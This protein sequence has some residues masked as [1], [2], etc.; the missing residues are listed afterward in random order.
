[1]ALAPAGF[2]SLGGDLLV[3]NFGDGVINAYDP[4]TFKFVGQVRDSAGKPISNTG[5][6]EIVFGTGSVGD[7]N[8][9]YFAAGI[10]GEKDG[11]FG[12][13]AV[14]TSSTGGGNFT[15]AASGA[16][17]TVTASQPGTTTLS[18]GSQNGFS[19]TVTLSCSGLP[20]D[21]TCSFSP[22]SVNLASSAT[23]SVTVSIAE[24]SSPGGGNPYETGRLSGLR[25]GTTLAFLGPIGLLAF[26]G[27]RRRSLFVRLGMLMAVAS[28]IAL[29][30]TGCSSSA[31]PTSGGTPTT[32]QV[33]INA[34]S[35]SITHTVPISVTLE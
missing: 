33:T 6:W 26:A 20:S 15:F 34:V 28:C 3:G 10:N 9:L 27:F 23:E 14:A 17:L 1:M 11:L 2:G 4:S 8:T 31:P 5:L 21:A 16:S 12:S 29:G 7:A 25:P 24:T 32:V 35:G 30:V 22:S 18:L 19:G 13:I